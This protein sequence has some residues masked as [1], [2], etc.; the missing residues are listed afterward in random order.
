M[1]DRSGWRK[2][3]RLAHAAG[4]AALLALAGT[5]VLSLPSRADVPPDPALLI[6]DM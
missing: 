4:I 6:T 3:W 1:R 5:M 2:A